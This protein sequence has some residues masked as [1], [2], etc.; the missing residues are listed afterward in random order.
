M[1][2]RYVLSKE[3][4]LD[5]TRILDAIAEEHGSARAEAV[6][7]RFREAFLLL[8]D[9]PFGGHPRPDLAGDPGIRFWTVFSYLVAYFPDGRPIEIVRVLHG[10]RGPGSLRSRG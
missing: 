10:A 2:A 5:L 4:H 8:A 9:A 6:S 3:A 1:T 7:D